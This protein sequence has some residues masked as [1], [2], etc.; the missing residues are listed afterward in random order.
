VSVPIDD[1][2]A[3][4]GEVKERLRDRVRGLMPQLTAEL[5]ELV[6]IPSV[7][8][9][10]YPKHTRPALRQAHEKVLELFRDAGCEDMSSIELADTAPIITGGIPAPDGA[11]TVLLYSHYDV[12]GPGDESEWSTPPFEPTVRDGAMYGRGAA[13]TKSNIVALAGALR[14]WDGRQHVGAR[15]VP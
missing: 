6:R 15:L 9:A 3:A 12:V 14:A 13:D 11:P 5:A 10:G 7:S 8:E 2:Q 4:P 1:T